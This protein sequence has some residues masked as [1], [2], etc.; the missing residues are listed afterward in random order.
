MGFERYTDVLEE[1][2]TKCKKWVKYGKKLRKNR[3]EIIEEQEEEFVQDVIDV[4][5]KPIEEADESYSMH[6]EVY[7]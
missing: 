7:D 3:K 5:E 4:K 6:I 1:Y 2:N